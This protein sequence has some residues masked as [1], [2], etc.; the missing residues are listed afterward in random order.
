M[1]KPL[2][3]LLKYWN[4]KNGKILTSF[5]I[6]QY[7]SSHVFYGCSNLEDYFLEGANWLSMAQAMTEDQRK[8]VKTLQLALSEIQ[9]YKQNGQEALAVL[10]LRSILPDL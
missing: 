2:I 6:E 3:R 1:L 10:Q 4:V 5:K 7:V 9:R 8:K